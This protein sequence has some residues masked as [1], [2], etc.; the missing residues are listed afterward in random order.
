MKKNIYNIG[1]KILTPFPKTKVFLKQVYRTTRTSYL[2]MR[3]PN[4]GFMR[5]NGAEV[6]CDFS[7]ENYAWYDGDSD[8]LNYELDVFTSLF[9]E[10]TP[11]I[12]LDVGAHW[13]FYPAFL[14][15]S[16]YAK[17]ISKLILIEAD[18]SN[19][20]ILSKTLAKINQFPV[21][22]VNAAISDKDGYINLYSGHDACTQTYYSP[23]TFPCGQV[24]AISLD[25]MVERF[26][27]NEG[28]ITH[29]KLDID[30]YEPA[31]FAGGTQILKRFKPIIM[32]EFWAKGLKVSGF[33][34]EEYW[35]MLQENYYVREACFPNSCLIPLNHED[36]TYLVNKT[37]DGI[38]NLVLVPKVV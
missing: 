26:L 28:V 1:K 23:N 29:V 13:G 19:N 34:L 30:G 37:I 5:C 11:D 8:F 16:I 18:P 36:L 24:Q 25:S 15:N 21:V 7:S 10:K 9:R 22:Q 31:F 38:T 17:I 32:M 12:V 3:H 2:K 20:D 33:N 27:K 6:F 14:S 4:G 35:N